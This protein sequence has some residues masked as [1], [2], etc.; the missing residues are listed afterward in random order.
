MT[1][2][3]A[4]LAAGRL[5][6]PDCDAPCAFGKAGSIPATVKRE[7]DLASPLGHWPVRRVF[8]RADRVAA[9]RTALR[10]DPIAADDGWCDA[11]G[12]PAYNRLVRL[13]FAE[14]HEALLREDGLYDLIVVLGHNDDPPKEALGSAIFLHCALPF[15]DGALRPTAGCVAVPRQDLVQLVGMLAP[16]D[17]IEIAA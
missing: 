12:H 11:P 9:P 7:G 16:G 10:T 4:S 3:T 17:G 5:T 8:Y 1:V 14:S 6:G 15:E 13:P 2:Y